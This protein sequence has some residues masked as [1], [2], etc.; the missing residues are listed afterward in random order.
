M[1]LGASPMLS[2]NSEMKLISQHPQS[3]LLS[4]KRPENWAQPLPRKVIG[5]R[6][7]ENIFTE[8]IFTSEV[9][10]FNDSFRI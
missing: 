9:Y 1:K 6:K 3:S 7:N 4:P 5:L 10:N 8:N 2:S